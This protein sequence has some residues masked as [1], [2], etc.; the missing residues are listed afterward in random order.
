[1]GLLQT[2]PPN[3]TAIEQLPAENLLKG[4]TEASSAFPLSTVSGNTNPPIALNPPI[5]VDAWNNPTILVPANG[6]SG[7]A[8]QEH[9]DEGPDH[10]ITSRGVIEPGGTLPAGVRPFFASA[11]PDG[12]FGWNDRNENG[13][14]DQDIDVPGG[15]DNIYSFEQ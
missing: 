13:T 15:D 8:F 3:K 2:M 10:I 9:L 11:G 4:P 6:L 7:V 1:M 12:I 5:L 14:F